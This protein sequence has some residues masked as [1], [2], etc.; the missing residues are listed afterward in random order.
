M[1]A[2]ISFG[3]VVAVLFVLCVVVGLPIFFL[4]FIIFLL[5]RNTKNRAVWQ[6]LSQD[7]N[8]TMVNPNQLQITGFYHNVEIVLSIGARRSGGEDSTTE[9]YT[10]CVGKFSSPLRLQL[11]I[12]SYSGAISRALDSAG[13]KTG[14]ANFDSA[15][16]LSCYDPNLIKQL[17]VADFP[18]SKTQNILGDL[19]LSH[20]SMDVVNVSDVGVYI[21]MGGMV[22][23]ANVLRQMLDMTAILTQRIHAAR[24]MLP[25]AEWEKKLIYSWL[26]VANEI[27]LELDSEQMILSGQIDKFASHIEFKTANEKWITEINL[28]FPASLFMGLKIMPDNSIHKALSWLGVQD[29]ESGIKEFDDAFIVKAENVAVARHRLQPEFCNRLISLRKKASDLTINDEE[30]TVVIQA[31]VGDETALKGLIAEII[32]VVK[33]LTR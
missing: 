33:L 15:F 16:L 4:F 17:I 19:M 10:Y 2:L 1:L 31:M 18:S 26:N 6:K 13:I 27:G 25:P 28:K 11:G 12:K 3:E 24:Q 30:I 29:I 23:D 20:Q 22:G 9:H 7:L 8:L 21:E 5:K 32:S 14:N